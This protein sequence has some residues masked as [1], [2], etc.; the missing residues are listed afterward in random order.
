M[1]INIA[2][3]MYILN[4]QGM[5]SHRCTCQEQMFLTNILVSKNVFYLLL[6]LRFSPCLRF[7][8][9]YLFLLQ[10]RYKRCSYLQYTDEKPQEKRLFAEQDSVSQLQFPLLQNTAFPVYRSCVLTP[11]LLKCNFSCTSLV[12]SMF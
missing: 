8:V 7:N 3:D 10:E 1:Y 6:C 12:E 9:F 11:P 4:S 5:L 2:G